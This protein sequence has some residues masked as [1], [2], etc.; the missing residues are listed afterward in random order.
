[1]QA[2]DC[3]RS[4]QD[5]ITHIRLPGSPFT[6]LASA[7]G[8]WVF[9]SLSSGSS[10]SGPGVA[11][12]SRSRGAIAVERIVP[13]RGEPT[14]MVLTHDGK[15]LIVPNGSGV[16]FLDVRRLEAGA[17]NAVLGYWGSSHGAGGHIYA[18]IT[19]DDRYLFVSD[20]AAGTISVINVA[21]AYRSHFLR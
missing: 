9:V 16:A 21:A 5:P 4:M 8:C 20:E 13:L 3:N 11:V 17:T 14:G 6:A 19:S 2:V 7:D 10:G 15:L 18:S 12:L 1:A